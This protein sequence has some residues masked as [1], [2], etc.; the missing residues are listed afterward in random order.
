MIVTNWISK[1][2]V[3]LASKIVP[4]TLGVTI[5]PFIYIWPP[6]AAKNKYLV[7]H[8]KKHI[9]QWLRYLVIG[10]LPLYIYQFLRYGYQKMPLEVEARRAE[11]DKGGGK[12]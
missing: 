2:V 7:R 5:W 10:F 3:R 9:E 4:G 11:K 8:E 1:Q 6:S 12:C